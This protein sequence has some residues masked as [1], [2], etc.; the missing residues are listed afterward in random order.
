MIVS[1]LVV[2]LSILD[3]VLRSVS[4]INKEESYKGIFLKTEA[5]LIAWFTL[6]LLIRFII[7]P[8][9]LRFFFSLFHLMDLISVLPYYIYLENQSMNQI[10]RIKNIARIFRVFNLIKLFRFSDSI[11]TI[12]STTKRS[13]KEMLVL[14]VYL[15]TGVLIFSTIV[16]YL[17]YKVKDSQFSSIPTVAWWAIITITTVGYGDLV[18]QTDLGRVFGGFCAIFGLIVI[19]LPI[20]LLTANFTEAY[21]FNKIKKKILKNHKLI[22]VNSLSQNPSRSSINNIEN[23]QFVI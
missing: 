7:C 1:S 19:A 5:S 10:E 8:S 12:L 17:E 22:K 11:S 2:I 14:C 21:R 16:F 4:W 18:P 3:I 23:D 20:S 13:Y 15:V 9:K 6:D